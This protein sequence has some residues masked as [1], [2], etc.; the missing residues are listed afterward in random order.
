[1][2]L[3]VATT[4]VYREHLELPPTARVDAAAA[5]VHDLRVWWEAT[6]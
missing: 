2:E 4:L 6:R 1:L 5:Y 3:I